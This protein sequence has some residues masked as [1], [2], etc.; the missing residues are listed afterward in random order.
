MRRKPKLMADS[1]LEEAAECLKVMAHPVRLRI[2]DAR[3]EEH[4]S[5]LQSR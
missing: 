4:T 1:V 2:V 5:E 3:S